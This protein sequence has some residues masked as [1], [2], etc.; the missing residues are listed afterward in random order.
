MKTGISYLRLLSCLVLLQA[1][2]CSFSQSKGLK[3]ITEKELR[4]HLEFLGAREF[5]GR[6]TP[7][8]ELEITTLYLGNWLKNAGLRPLMSD[9][10]FYQSVP[11]TVTYVFQPNTK[12]MLSRGSGEQIYYF[13]KGFS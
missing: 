2:V 5:R 11:L 8:P 10:T 13:G 7:S 1:G 9:G 3:T 6:E 12:L 4:Y